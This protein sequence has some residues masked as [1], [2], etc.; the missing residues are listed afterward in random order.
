MPSCVGYCVQEFL[1][2]SLFAFLHVMTIF[3][4]LLVDLSLIHI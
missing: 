3:F 2:A 1:V 4:G